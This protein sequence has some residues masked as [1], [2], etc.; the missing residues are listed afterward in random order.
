[1]SF[2]VTSL[3][4]AAAVALALSSGCSSSSADAASTTDLAGAGG[5]SA[6]GG[7]GTAGTGGAGGSAANGVAGGSAGSVGAAGK[8]GSAGAAGKSGSAGVGG[9]KA[10]GGAGGSGATA[11]AAGTT[12]GAAGTTG[13]AAGSGGS[14]LSYPAFHP[15]VPQVVNG[16]GP[17]LAS[18]VFVPVVFPA[19]TFKTEIDDF[20]PKAVVSSA[21]AAELTEYGVGAGVA[22]P[23][24]TSSPLPGASISQADLESF[25]ASHVGVGAWGTPDTGEFGSQFYVLF[26][27]PGVSVLLPSGKTTCG[28][29]PY[30]YHRSV[31]VGATYVPYAVVANCM[32]GIV[33]ITK[34]A[35]HEIVEGCADPYIPYSKAFSKAGADWSFAFN[36]SEIGDMCEHRA[37]QKIT[38]PDIGY[39]VQRTWSNAAAL[40]YHD[41]CV[42][43]P[44]APFF[45]AAPVLPG[46]VQLGMA[47][48]PGVQI[49]VG[50][51]TT[52]DVQLFSDGPTA[53]PFD[54]AAKE[55]QGGT[56]LSFAWD[57]T[58]GQNGDVLHLT[59]SAVAAAPG[60]TTFELEASLGGA[61][62]QWVGAVGN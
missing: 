14:A 61:S 23:S 48:V 20:F 13:G 12:G 46:T 47:M 4:T 31:K 45:A 18:P 34:I 37:D 7:V 19:T 53:G 62:S 58:S 17:V 30:G 25:V 2:R 16:G 59:I 32:K 9:S 28:A 6:G 11:G 29:G 42:P 15:P 8:S 21:W 24:V 33:P 5:A 49:A 27:P 60:G 57:K 51:S 1:M 26:L 35:W 3:L 39:V 41:P 36:G 55:S 38:P 50:S 22:V 40:A 10:T 44:S 54:V 56:S 52:I 43:A